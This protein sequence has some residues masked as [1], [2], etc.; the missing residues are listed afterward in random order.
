M[1][2]KKKKPCKH[3]INDGESVKKRKMQK[4]EMKFRTRITGTRNM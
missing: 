4:E 3:E 2:I 1:K